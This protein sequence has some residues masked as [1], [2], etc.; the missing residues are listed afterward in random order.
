[1]ADSIET[2]EVIVTEDIGNLMAM[3]RELGGERNDGTLQNALLGFG[4]GA[5]GL[6]TDV[7][8][9]NSAGKECKLSRKQ[10][11]NLFADDALCERVCTFMPNQMAGSGWIAD[12]KKDEEL[13]QW[14]IEVSLMKAF[15]E[16][17]VL[18]NIYNVGAGIVLAIDDGRRP[19]EPVDRKKIKSVKVAFVRDGE[20]LQPVWQGLTK[21]TYYNVSIAVQD[22]QESMG[23]GKGQSFSSLTVHPDRVLWF[24]GIWVPLRVERDRNGSPSL[25]AR[26]WKQYS[27]WEMGNKIAMNLLSRISIVNYQV[28]GWT[29]LLASNTPEAIAEIRTRL[30]VLKTMTSMGI[31]ISDKS[32]NAVEVISRQL[33]EVANILDRLERGMLAASGMSRMDVFGFAEGAGLSN[34]DIRDRMF[35]ADRVLTEQTTYWKDPLETVVGY[36]LS[37]QGEEDKAL[38]TFKS[39]LIYTRAETIAEMS[40]IGVVLST[41][42]QIGAISADEYRSVLNDSPLFKDKFKGKAPVPELPPEEEFP[43]E[44]FPPEETPAEE[45]Y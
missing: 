34:D 44:E 25:L 40:A 30:Q 28:E 12:T 3:L 45:G 4:G 31:L 24:P 32:K 21:P 6:E 16:A 2:P 26:F 10:L 23:H 38:V 9:Y 41:A 18:A 29:A 39:T 5:D 8:A 17:S 11:E 37:S 27:R 13:Q 43:P 20:E 33:A 22:F 42:Q 7:E 36:W 14:A 15:R 19:D 35:R 1:M